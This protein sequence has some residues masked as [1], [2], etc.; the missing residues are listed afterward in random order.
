MTSK[1][2]SIAIVG[3]GAWGLSTALHLRWAG[4]KNITVF[5]RAQ[6]IP[7]PYSAAYDINKIARAEYEDKFY[8]KLALTGYVVRATSS[9]PKKATDHLEKALSSIESDP[10]F[11]PGI[12]RLQSAKDFK[13]YTW[14]YSGPLTGFR[15]YFNRL[16][17]YAHSSDALSGAWEECVRLGVKFVQGDEA[18]RVVRLRC[19][20]SEP[21]E[22]TSRQYRCSGIQTADGKVHAT[23]L[24]ICALGA[25]AA[26]ILPG[27]G[28]SV[29]ARC[30]SVAHVQLDEQEANFLRGI[31]TT[32]IRDLGFFFEP[33][34]KTHLF[35]LCPLGVGYTNPGKD[36]VSLPPP[37]RFLLL[38]TSFRPKMNRS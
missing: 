22:T 6:K 34:P 15:G 20:T 2:S 26:S 14:Q 31:P 32:N 7:S 1:D 29:Q 35:K 5:E 16:A 38:K 27:L 17:G 18:G 12:R 19:G 21:T 9:A 24:T 30:W 33:D 3:G 23:D 37:D 11:A 10:A 28:D 8:S 4:Y 13:E 25:H 36:D